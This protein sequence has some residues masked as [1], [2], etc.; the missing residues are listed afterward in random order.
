MTNNSQTPNSKRKLFFGLFI[1]PLVIAVGMALMLCTVV[2]LTSEKETPETLI[3]SIKS[4]S[5]SKR[6]QKAFELS[7]ELNRPNSTYL[8]N[9]ALMNEIISIARDT[10]HFDVKTRVYM[11]IAL[12]HFNT[13]A[14]IKA[15]QESLNDES[16]ELRIYSIWSLGVLRDKSSAPLIARFLKS[17]SPDI[18][19]MA[20]YA[21]GV[22]G[23]EKYWDPIKPLLDDAV[24]DVRWNAALS[25]ARL[26]SDAG[27]DILIQMLDRKTYAALGP[28]TEQEI[29]AAM[30]NAIKGLALIHK[31]K[32]ITI[33]STVSKQEQNMNVRQTAIDAIKIIEKSLK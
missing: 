17:D 25:L 30:I 15:L 33:L 1:F 5:P 12:S 18:K 6:W 21:I 24:A 28:I 9:T 20:L 32:S 31:P 2:F 11:T 16:D 23:D 14:S 8:R 10:Q 3:G 22:L 13:P 4:G 29:E 26:G 19:K 27:Y 7:N